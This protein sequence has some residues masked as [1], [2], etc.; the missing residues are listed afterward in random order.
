MGVLEWLSVKDPYTV[1]HFAC[2]VRAFFLC[3]IVG[4]AVST[5]LATYVPGIGN[6]GIVLLLC[7]FSVLAFALIRVCAYPQALAGEGHHTD[8]TYY[9]RVEDPTLSGQYYSTSMG[10]YLSALVRSRSMNNLASFMLR[11]SARSKA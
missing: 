4:M 9:G 2:G 8:G 3:A 10:A 1:G 11:M 6:H 5:Y 7:P